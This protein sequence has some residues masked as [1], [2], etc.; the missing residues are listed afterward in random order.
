MFERNTKKVTVP[1]VTTKRVTVPTM[2]GLKKLVAPTVAGAA[3]KSAHSAQEAKSWTQAKTTDLAQEARDVAGPALA[4]A[5]AKGEATKERVDDT[6][7]KVI[8]AITGAL[9]AGAATAEHKAHQAADVVTGEAKRKEKRKKGIIGSLFSG[10]L[11]LA[12]AGAVIAYLRKRQSQPQDDPWARPLTDPYVA[13]TTGRASSTGTAGTAGTPGT[14]DAAGAAGT[15]GVA[16]AA[17]PSSDDLPYAVDSK[18]G[19][20][21]APVSDLAD[22]PAVEV[23]E[24]EVVDLT[25]DGRPPAEGG[26]TPS[27]P[28]QDG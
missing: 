3:A 7:P 27:T 11:T 21:E 14:P 8:E 19:D 16:G 10:L 6:I 26:T 12:A 1:T 25:A 4:T 5:A 17:T 15:A 18:V 22:T 23:S 24:A 13:P 2:H 9:A 20:S 28:R